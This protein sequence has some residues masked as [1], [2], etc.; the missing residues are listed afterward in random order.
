M[1]I[2]ARV[3]LINDERRKILKAI[4]G[5][6]TTING[7][8]DEMTGTYEKIRDSY[9]KLIENEN[10]MVEFEIADYEESIARSR[11]VSVILDAVGKNQV[12]L[13]YIIHM[14]RSNESSLVSLVDRNLIVEV[15]SKL[16][17]QEKISVVANVSL[18]YTA[19]RYQRMDRLI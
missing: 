2:D 3:L 11:L 8:Y 5:H 12:T 9:D 13:D 19:I 6:I 1:V 4:T 7:M 16:I 17:D 14:V 15:L 10:R 18:N